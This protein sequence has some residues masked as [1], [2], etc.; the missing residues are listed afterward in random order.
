MLPVKLF[1]FGVVGTGADQIE[2]EHRACR[3]P[4]ILCAT[5]SIKKKD[6]GTLKFLKLTTEENVQHHTVTCKLF[7]SLDRFLFIAV[8][9]VLQDQREV[10]R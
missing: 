3:V 4:T 9:A 10:F 8:G 7:F 5:T 6:T 2:A 1:W